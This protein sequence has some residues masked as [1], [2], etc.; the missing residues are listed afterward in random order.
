MNDDLTQL[1]MEAWAKRNLPARLV[2]VE[3]AKLLGFAGHDIAT[4]IKA[5]KLKPLGNPPPN[6][7]K[8]FSAVELI[9][10]VMDTNWLNA[11]TR[12]VTK[13][14]KNKNARRQARATTQA[15]QTGS[16]EGACGGGVLLPPAGSAGASGCG[17]FDQGDDHGAV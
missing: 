16:G 14:W 5:G 1:V 9:R 10:L 8:Y 17:Y 4:L 12:D 6:T 11:A 2:S 13:F 3:A 15:V 7:V